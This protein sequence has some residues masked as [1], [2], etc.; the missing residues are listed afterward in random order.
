[1]SGHSIGCCHCCIGFSKDSQ[2]SR[3][4]G[5]TGWFSP[6]S[7]ASESQIDLRTVSFMDFGVASAADSTTHQ[8]A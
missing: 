4:A 5:R 6:G 3:F 2:L 1:M 8:L 7:F